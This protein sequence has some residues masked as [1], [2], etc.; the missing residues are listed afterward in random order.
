M[1]QAR[2]FFTCAAQLSTAGANSDGAKEAHL[3][4]R[5]VTLPA[6]NRGSA[7]VPVIVLT[8]T[9]AMPHNGAM[10]QLTQRGGA[11]RIWRCTPGDLDA[12]CRK[13]ARATLRVGREVLHV[14]SIA[15]Q[16]AVRLRTVP[17]SSIPR[18]LSTSALLVAFGSYSNEPAHSSGVALAFSR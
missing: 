14:S 4:P 18:E 8:P 17:A 9:P 7:V 6:L 12:V 10:L 13:T 2:S 1:S 11:S 16:P 5:R 3:S 15:R